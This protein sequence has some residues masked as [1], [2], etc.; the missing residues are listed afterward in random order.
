MRCFCGFDDIKYARVARG[1]L[2]CP[3][4]SGEIVCEP[5]PTSLCSPAQVFAAVALSMRR[6]KQESFWVF[7]LDVRNHLIGKYEV[8]KGSLAS[9]MVHP[10]E[11]FAG[12]VSKHAAAV[13]LMHNHP[14]GDP[15]PSGQL[16]RTKVRGL[17][18]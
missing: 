8:C 5:V 11:I 9:C 7:L 14:S 2:I 15:T 17:P 6:R 1:K 16:P 3:Y 4:C 10:R 12:A 18:E 13:I